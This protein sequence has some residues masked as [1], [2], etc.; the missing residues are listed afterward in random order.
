MLD[1]PH[2]G[3]LVAV[4]GGRPGEHAL[5]ALAGGWAPEPPRS[6]PPEE[7]ELL[8]GA[9]AIEAG[10]LLYALEGGLKNCRAVL[11]PDS[12]S[13]PPIPLNA[14]T[15]SILL[16]DIIDDVSIAHTA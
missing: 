12:C 14:D 7:V 15:M 4:G 1:A 11:Q 6:L 16:N 13:Q 3:G 5:C 10:K 9:A 2:E 8:D